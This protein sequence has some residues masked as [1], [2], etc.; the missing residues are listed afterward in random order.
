MELKGVFHEKLQCYCWKQII[1][2][3]IESVLHPIQ[4]VNAELLIILD[5]IERLRKAHALSQK[6]TRE[7]I[8]DGIESN[9]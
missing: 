7:I 6:K 4:I 9:S 3:G 1:L 5:G 2:D 8:L